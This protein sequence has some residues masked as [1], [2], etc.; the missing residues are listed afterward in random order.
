[1]KTLFNEKGTNDLSAF[2]FD[3]GEG[4]ISRIVHYDDER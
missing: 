4:E 3:D 1:M 2:D